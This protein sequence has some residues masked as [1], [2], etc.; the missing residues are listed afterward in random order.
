[1]QRRKIIVKI[2]LFH[3]QVVAKGIER[4]VG[5]HKKALLFLCV[6]HALFLRTGKEHRAEPENEK[7]ESHR[8]L[9][10]G[11]QVGT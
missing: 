5:R 7:N 10:K 8:H 9:Q 6:D 3:L 2:L 4:F 11:L 1:M